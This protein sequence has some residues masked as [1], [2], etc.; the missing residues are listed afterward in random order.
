MRVHLDLVS[1]EQSPAIPVNYNHLISKAILKTILP[2]EPEFQNLL[3]TKGLRGQQTKR[4][5]LFTFSGLR[6]H[7]PRWTLEN[8]QFIFKEPA[9][10]Q[11]IIS[12]SYDESFMTKHIIPLLQNATLRIP[13]LGEDTETNLKVAALVAKPI[14]PP[15]PGTYRVLAPITISRKVKEEVRYLSPRH[16]ETNRALSDDLIE[17]HEILTGDRLPQGSVTIRVDPT[18]LE[19]SSQPMKVITIHAGTPD[20]VRVRAF[21]APIQ[22]SG[23]PKLIRTAIACGVGERN[24]LGFGILGPMMTA[25]HATRAKAIYG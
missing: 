8:G 16:S 4:F 19:R 5:R 6:F 22:I 13:V 14:P 18:Y 10:A 20:E 11:L 24:H 3:R 2:A 12:F 17:K 1:L 25:K 7:G 21:I 23:D 9:Q 15:Q